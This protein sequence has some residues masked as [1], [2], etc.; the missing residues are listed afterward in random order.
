MSW[1]RFWNVFKQD[2][3]SHW[4]RPLLWVLLIIV[5]F[6]S[7]VFSTSSM[8]P[9]GDSDVGGVKTFY[10]SEF[11]IAYQMTFMVALIYAFF[12]TAAAGLVIITDEEQKTGEL[13]HATPLRAGEYI[14]GKFAAVMATFLLA[15]VLN[16]L[17]SMFFF[18]A[19]PS[20]KYAEMRGPWLL[21]A[22][23][24]PAFFMVL[25]NLVFLCGFSFAI[26]ERTRKPILVFALPITLFLLY[27][28]FLWEW[29]PAWLSLTWNRML[30][31]LDPSGQRWFAETWTKVP[32]GAA[33][34]NT[35]KIG[36]DG[37]FLLSRLTFMAAGLGAVAWS[38]WRFRK[39]F[40]GQHAKPR[41]V[42]AALALDGEELATAAPAAKSFKEMAMSSGRVGLLRGLWT[43][44]RFELKGLLR[45]PGLYIFAPIIM[46]ITGVM[47]ADA[48]PFS[49]LTSGGLAVQSF[50][51]LTLLLCFLFLFY[52]VESLNRERN[53]GLEGILSSTK[54]PTFSLL[55]GKAVANSLVGAVILMAS[56]LTCLVFLAM[57]NITPI[58]AWPFLLVWGLLMIPTFLVWT[59]F[60][61]AVQ[62][63]AR[64]RYTTYA[65]G[66]G[67]I[68]VTAICNGRGLM[69]WAGNWPLWNIPQW[70]D[71]STFELDRS[72]LVLNRLMVLALAL[73]FTAFAAKVHARQERDATAT[74]HRCRPKTLGMAVL[75]MIP[76]AA[77][78]IVVIITLGV[79]VGTGYQS[80]SQE[81]IDKDYWRKNVETYKDYPT[82]AIS[83]VEL[84]LELDPARRDFKVTGSYVLRNHRA[85]A[86][87]QIPITLKP[88][89]KDVT[90]T[91]DGQPFKP[92]DRAGLQILTANG[93][94]LVPGES[95]K[96]GFT[97]HGRHLEGSSKN[98][99][100]A[101]SFILPSGVVLTPA[102]ITP[103]LGFQEDIGIDKD[104]KTDPKEFT[105]KWYDGVTPSLFG[106][107]TDFT[108]RIRIT[109]PA[110]YIYNSVGVKIE[111]KLD[112]KKR[113]VLWVSDHPVSWFNVVAGRWKMQQGTGTAIYYHPGHAYN[114]KEMGEALDASRKY[115]SEWFYPFPW[116]ELKLS[117]FPNL[118]GYA[119]GFPTNIVFS[120]GIGFLT[121]SGPKANPIFHVTAHEAAHQWWGNILIPGEGPGGNVISEGLAEYSTAQ[122]FGQL[123][124]AQQRMAFMSNNETTYN[125]GRVPD[126]ERSLVELWGNRP[127]EYAITYEKGGWAF[128]M[129]S[130]LMGPEAF[131]AGLRDFL[132]TYV[133]NPDHPVIQ[134]L[135]PILRTHAPDEKAYDEFVQ[136]WFYQV[137]VPEYRVSDAIST[138]RPDG[139]WDV[140]F[141]ITNVG[142]GRMPLC[143][144]ATTK[145]AR[146]LEEEDT[147]IPGKPNPDYKDARI[148]CTIDKGEVLTL[149]VRCP[150]KPDRIVPDPDVLV[151]Q[152]N[153]K[154]AV[155]K[156]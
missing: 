81:K 106:N 43:V 18:H 131:H 147:T 34:Y 156:L 36:F 92:T 72:S 121:K 85:F 55:A 6:M 89:F 112:G 113:S 123:K 63:V 53:V 108:T 144:A 4:K 126:S 99:G 65:V 103:M 70:S 119:Q 150:F 101:R 132:K 142:S 125:R 10:N 32:R 48:G 68:A 153:R 148:N 149:T 14:W 26:G 87:E 141:R 78:P 110:D 16:M 12:L 50:N 82:P 2:L 74:L 42:D 97:F 60:V 8:M 83:A 71:I 122:L 19:I 127:G 45:E 39:E 136:Q 7:W 86:L 51:P 93:K 111:D 62:A 56:G 130:E 11:A 20:A 118:S 138:E 24:R 129:L 15:L 151:L 109:G 38:H 140:T 46:I 49:L 54:I 146:F 133:N 120:E 98:G 5:A 13:L 22:Y 80:K 29:S 9:A 137:V 102:D 23:L 135:L 79:R 66:L 96:V 155:L 143:V 77:L 76:Y 90:W 37:P 115:Y 152:L 52:G 124:G 88:T 105:G 94:A 3:V 59:A 117:E 1:K 116:K 58:Q 84:D 114:V 128:Y 17:L 28:F 73:F 57:Q 40:R 44:A 61:N 75:R 67:A 100:G 47:A 91:V 139:S 69:N 27:S 21:S 145:D 107:D 35:G 134:D 33:F 25:P 64:N 154:Q 31:W 95:I 30:Q 104:N 41:E